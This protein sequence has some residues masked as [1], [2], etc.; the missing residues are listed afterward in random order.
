MLVVAGWPTDEAALA[1]K[2]SAYWYSFAVSKDG[3]PNPK[4]GDHAKWPKYTA[5]VSIVLC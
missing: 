3:D 4:Q 1:Q 2:I 5:D